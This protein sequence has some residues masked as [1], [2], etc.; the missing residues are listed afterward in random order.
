MISDTEL[1]L[2]NTGLLAYI[3]FRVSVV[4]DDGDDC[5]VNEESKCKHAAQAAEGALEHGHVLGRRD[6]IEVDV[7]APYGR[8]VDHHADQEDHGHSACN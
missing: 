6:V 4:R 3:I 7:D 5:V 1:H 2:Q 8:V